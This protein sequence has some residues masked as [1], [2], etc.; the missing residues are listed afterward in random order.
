MDLHVTFEG[1][2]SLPYNIFVCYDQT[3]SFYIFICDS[4]AISI[5]TNLRQI[6]LSGLGSEKFI[7]QVYLSRLSYYIEGLK[8]QNSSFHSCKNI[9]EEPDLLVL[10]S[11]SVKSIFFQPNKSNLQA[12]FHMK[13]IVCY[14]LQ[15]L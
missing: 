5:Y 6:D 14:V 1:L 3:G 9:Y 13:E 15:W 12:C 2:Y 8:Y 10:I 11:I 7:R 4:D